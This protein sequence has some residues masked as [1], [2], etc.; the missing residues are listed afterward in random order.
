M[1]SG[2]HS[3][4]DEEGALYIC[5]RDQVMWMAKSWS[6]DV[7]GHLRKFRTEILCYKC[8]CRED[9]HVI[10]FRNVWG[11]F[12]TCSAHTSV[13]TS[14]HCGIVML[15]INWQLYDMS[16]WPHP[17]PQTGH[18][19]TA[20]IAVELP[21]A[22]KEVDSQE[23]G[24]AQADPV[25][26]KP[27]KM[28]CAM[29][30]SIAG[31]E[32]NSSNPSGREGLKVSNLPGPKTHPKQRLVGSI[33]AT[34]RAT[35]AWEIGRG[36]RTDRLDQTIR[37]GHSIPDVMHALKFP[38]AT[39]QTVY[40]EIMG[41]GKIT[42]V[43]DNCLDVQCI[44]GSV[45]VSWLCL[46]IPSST[47]SSLWSTEGT[48]P[49]SVPLLTTH[50]KTERL[51]WALEH[52]HSTWTHGKKLSE[53]KNR[54][55]C[56]YKLMAGYEC[57]IRHMKRYIPR[58]SRLHTVQIGGG[59][60]VSPQCNPDAMNGTTSDGVRL[61]AH[62]K[63][64]HK[65]SPH[66]C[67]RSAKHVNSPRRF[68]F[69]IPLAI[70]QSQVA[71][72]IT[73]PRGCVTTTTALH[74]LHIVPRAKLDSP[75]VKYTRNHNGKPSTAKRR[76]PIYKKQQQEIPTQK[77]YCD[78][79]IVTRYRNQLSDHM[80]PF[81]CLQHLAG[82]KLP[83]RCHP[84]SILWNTPGMM[85]RCMCES[86]TLFGPISVHYERLSSNHRSRRLTDCFECLVE[87][88]PSC[89]ATIRLC[90]TL[91][92][93]VIEVSMEQR[94]NEE[95]GKREIAEKTCR[96][97]AS[98]G[99]IPVRRADRNSLHMHMY[100]QYA[101]ALLPPHPLPAGGV[102]YESGVEEYTCGPFDCLNPTDEV[103][104]MMRLA[105]KLKGGG[106]DSWLG[107]ACM[108]SSETACHAPAI[109]RAAD[110][111]SRG[112]VYSK[113]RGHFTPFNW[114]VSA[115][116]L[117]RFSLNSRVKMSVCR[118]CIN[119][120][121]RCRNG[122]V[123][124]SR[125]DGDSRRQ[126]IT[127]VGVEAMESAELRSSREWRSMI[128]PITLKYTLLP[129][130]DAFH[131]V[132]KDKGISS[133]DY[134]HAQS[135]W[136]ALSG[137]HLLEY[138]IQYLRMDRSSE[139]PP[140]GKT[141]K[142]V[143]T[144]TQLK[145]YIIHYETLKYYLKYGAKLDAVHHILCFKQNM[146]D[147]RVVLRYDT[148]YG[149]AELIGRPTSKAQHMIDENLVLIEM[150]IVSVTFN[151]LSKGMK[152]NVLQ[153][154]LYEDYLECVMQYSRVMGT[155]FDLRLRTHDI[156]TE[157]IAKVAFSSNDNKRHDSSYGFKRET[158]SLRGHI[159]NYM[160]SARCEASFPGSPQVIR[161]HHSSSA[162][163]V[164]LIRQCAI[165]LRGRIAAHLLGNPQ[166]HQLLNPSPHPKTHPISS[167]FQPR[168]VGSS[169]RSDN[170][171]TP[172]LHSVTNSR[173]VNMCNYSQYTNKI[174]LPS[175]GIEPSTT[176]GRQRSHSSDPPTHDTHKKDHGEGV[177]KGGLGIITCHTTPS[178]GRGV[179]EE[180]IRLVA[181]LE[182]FS[183][184]EPEKRDND[185]GESVT[186]IKCAIAPKRKALNW[187]AMFSS[188]CE[189]SRRG[190]FFPSERSICDYE[191]G[192]LD[193]GIRT[194][195]INRALLSASASDAERA[196]RECTCVIC[197][198][199]DSIST[200]RRGKAS[201]AR[202]MQ[203][204]AGERD[205]ESQGWDEETTR[206]D[207]THPSSP[208][209]FPA[210][211]PPPS[212][213]PPITMAADNYRAASGMKTARERAKAVSREMSC[214]GDN[215][216]TFRRRAAESAEIPPVS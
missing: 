98:S 6:G 179:V 115:G 16:T 197:R 91:I 92:G 7:D 195:G 90:Y 61:W 2:P 209:L 93:R 9:P 60:I 156:F 120:A 75:A 4:F 135:T 3:G 190:G 154:L 136:N 34:D 94:R 102:P 47:L 97:A 199:C 27:K 133:A 161:Q 104:R 159:S 58:V 76:L 74:D 144:L 192:E 178:G 80:F 68:N 56:W 212:R 204:Y 23:G 84:T 157:S 151:S 202:P 112:P 107:W 42:A 148:V 145:N 208:P 32:T 118:F 103:G 44:D 180:P 184:F 132:M 49:L 106:L 67:A 21:N 176:T 125:S 186:R 13:T 78:M 158:I 26:L 59:G 183:A 138:E 12:T 213:F 54:G 126:D 172:P 57:F 10:G 153:S 193:R 38:R 113:L 200:A 100:M 39:A 185:K 69:Q 188:C 216:R 114:Y 73:L 48:L 96:P 83:F 101:P 152:S 29:G 108:E 140:N 99:T 177:W 62:I 215:S 37:M 123:E 150:E 63:G 163:S 15:H 53:R 143:L 139:I 17:D 129:P 71:Q 87:S 164:L 30:T 173:R 155:Q 111:S 86:W 211:V 95:A 5:K 131:S 142:L 134:A 82:Y 160:R 121:P 46:A 189:Y 167:P 169:S 124:P 210:N 182:L 45:A 116:Q 162:R 214:F 28:S 165:Q 196:S 201:S 77:N 43:R 20:S 119:S 1:T 128:P 40:P 194:F 170:M 149:V 122:D 206:R 19:P 127:Q 141:E 85:S 72:R 22:L 117:W 41:S 36:R 50:Q 70:S 52:R 65:P 109:Q 130:K 174:L 79:A 181:H 205:G 11:I 191:Q 33:A 207:S 166:P 88:I 89:I 55:L 64:K 137:Q 168:Q 171:C 31:L 14:G 105:G 8:V 187:C 146:C 25:E 51:T 198:L 175:T 110:S 66:Y 35:I 24:G 147:V 18:C 203:D 81:L